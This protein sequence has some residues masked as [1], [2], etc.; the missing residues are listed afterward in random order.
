MA[1]GEELTRRQVLRWAAATGAAAALGGCS[2]TR[3]TERAGA[4][5]GRATAGAG[6]R[7]PTAPTPRPDWARLSAQLTT[8]VIRPGS[9][10]YAAAARLYNPRFDPESHPQAV[11]FCASSQDVAACVRFA[12]QTGTG[13]R[14]RSGGHSYGGWSTGPDLVA[15]V[16]RISGVVVDPASGTARIGAGASLVEV[17]AALAQRGVALAAGSCPTVGMTGLLLGGGVGVL[18]RAFGLTCDALLGVEI[19]TADGRLRHVTARHDP[20]LFWASRGGGG[21]SFGAVTALTVAVRPSPEV[22]TFYLSWS[23]PAALEVVESWQNW[24]A[25]AEPRL[26]STC[27]LLA[28]AG[29]P[30]LRVVVAGTWLGAASDVDPQLAGL[31]AAVS[32]PPVANERSTLSYAAAM[33]LE[34]GCAGNSAAQCAR[35]ALD[36]QQDRPF[37]ATSAILGSPLPTAGVEAAVTAARAGLSLPGVVEAG[38]SFDA[39]GG[40]VSRV[41]PTDT[42]F[43]YRD[44]LAT[45]QY[46]AT[47][48]SPGQAATPFDAH[49]QALRT[50]LRPW[51]GATAYVNYPDPAILDYGPAYWGRNYPRLQAV[52]RQ[53]DPYG[54]FTFPQAVRG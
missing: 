26:W 50:A 8:P 54:L 5:P 13:L 36:P 11:A 7:L 10:G 20:D 41:A 52:K 35:A 45:V 46:T 2:T 9:S 40:A 19:V 39:L 22:T 12:A 6:R 15:D 17:Y 49:V 30:G 16:S 48:A 23:D 44:A 33:L 3:A 42:A 25:G 29:Q 1:S 4:P 14:L 27:K 21:G 34:A 32:P 38:T 24:V 31:F 18:T 37:A 53:Y 51:T 47:W 28:D 43:P